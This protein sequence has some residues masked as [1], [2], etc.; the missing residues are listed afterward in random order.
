MTFTV[1]SLL[2]GPA[3]AKTATFAFEFMPVIYGSPKVLSYVPS[4]VTMTTDLRLTLTLQNVPRFAIPFDTSLVSLAIDNGPALHATAILESSRSQ[5]T[6]S[7]LAPGPWNT[8]TNVLNISVCVM[9]CTQSSWLSIDVLPPADPTIQ[10]VFP[11]AISSFGSQQLA[12]T[13]A[14]VQQ[15][16]TLSQVSAFMTTGQQRVAALNATALRRISPAGCSVRDC[17]VFALTLT[18]P[19]SNPDGIDV[20]GVANISIS[21]GEIVMSTTISYISAAAP[22]LEMLS[23]S[24][25]LLQQLGLEPIEVIVKNF[26]SRDC[27]MTSTCAQEAT[28]GNLQAFIGTVA[29]KVVSAV[30]RKNGLLSISMLAP[31]FNAASPGLRG[32]VQATIP[33]SRRQT[34]VE[35]AF[36]VRAAPPTILPSEGP[37]EGGIIVTV[38]A[39]GWGNLSARISDVVSFY[40]H[41]DMHLHLHAHRHTDMFIYFSDKI[42]YICVCIHTCI[43]IYTRESYVC[44]FISFE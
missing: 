29:A 12:V 26:P 19:Q 13:L 35:F 1:S 18:S 4:S 3:S 6:L 27:A 41:I 17:T 11:R 14:F 25:Q 38:T 20:G 42:T 32:M 21:Y 28:T 22:S 10:S 40:M 34:L 30:D 43:H 31:Q 16:L 9:P 33:E 44:M 5:T 15:S 24:Y 7:L 8:N 2:G 37:L 39:R 36:D 23:P